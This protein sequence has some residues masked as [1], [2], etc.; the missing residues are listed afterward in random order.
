MTAPSNAASNAALAA[1]T[2]FRPIELTE[3]LRQAMLMERERSGRAPGGEPSSR[4]RILDAAEELFGAEGPD[5]VSLRDVSARSGAATGL[6]HYHFPTKENLVEEV[7][8]RRAAIVSEI[9]RRELAKLGENPSLAALLDAFVRPLIELASGADAGWASYC[10][11]ISRIA[12]SE[13][14]GHMIVKHLDET[15]KVFVQA[16]KRAAPQAD[17]TEVVYGFGFTV[18]LMVNLIVKNRRI[19][20]MAEGGLPAEDIGAIYHRMMRY[21]VAGMQAL[22]VPKSV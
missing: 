17:E 11:L 1:E 12:G 7:V 20:S 6:I 16:L 4:D 18:M 15:A 10:G 5:V 2:D 3:T 9:R 22:C 13:T 21:S 8:A 19:Q 14:R